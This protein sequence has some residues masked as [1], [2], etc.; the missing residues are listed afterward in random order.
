MTNSRSSYNK[1]LF[2]HYVKIQG[3]WLWGSSLCFISYY[4]PSSEYVNN[5][6]AKSMECVPPAFGISLAVSWFFYDYHAGL[7]VTFGCLSHIALL[8][9]LQYQ[10]NKSCK[11]YAPCQAQCLSLG[12]RKVFSV[13]LWNEIKWRLTES[14][15]ILIAPSEQSSNSEH[16]ACEVTVI[17]LSSRVPIQ[18]EA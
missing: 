15:A 16:I 18:L 6:W 7:W 13:K 4:S 12:M 11:S 8:Q 2:S 1:K 10:G 3:S 5:L 17:P 14:K 9:S